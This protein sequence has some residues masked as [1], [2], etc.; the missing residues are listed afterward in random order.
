LHRRIRRSESAS[1]S[2]DALAPSGPRTRHPGDVRYRPD[3]HVAGTPMNTLDAKADLHRWLQIGRDALLWK[4][5]G[6]SEYDVR[7]PLVP[8]GTNLLGLV[9]HLAAVEAGYFGAVFGRPFPDPMPWDEDDPEPNDDMW[10]RPHESRDDIIDLYRRAWAHADATIGALD[11]GSIGEVPWWPAERREV[12]LHRILVH[13]ATETH[14]HAGHADI[15]REL[16][17]G[18]IGHRPGV[19]N[20]PGMD[21]DWWQAHHDQIEQAAREAAGI[22]KADPDPANIVALL[23]GID[24]A[25]E[26]AQAGW[27]QAQEGDTVPLDEL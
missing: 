16:I 7:R 1:G 19:D 8:T 26:A 2:R 10:A 13:I 22:S 4:L 21:A 17:D 11:L 3:D 12:T 20:L 15:I 6:A 9:K 14:R 23:D 18:A 25:R 27:R 24:G 5:D